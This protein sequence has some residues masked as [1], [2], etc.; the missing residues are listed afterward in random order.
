MTRITTLAALAAAAAFALPAAAQD[1]PVAIGAG[2]GTTGLNVEAQARLTSRIVL[3]GTYETL[4]FERDQEV[5]DIDYSGEIESD[6]FGGYVQFHPTEGPF[7]LTAGVLVGERALG[8]DAEPT[9]AVTVGDVTFTPD[10]IGRLEGDAD[11]GDTAPVLGLGWDNTFARESRWGWRVMAGVA[12]G[13]EPDVTLASVGGTLS[14]TA[15]VQAEL[16]E[17]EAR[18][19]EDADVLRY[20]PVL[21]V[22]LTYRF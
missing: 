18:L 10:E 1:G 4:S 20:Y 21:Q 8:L 2:V 12:M 7:F 14:D 17:E 5:D 11:F 3:R 15:E 22:G 9:T 19:E 13:Q 6:V 16:R